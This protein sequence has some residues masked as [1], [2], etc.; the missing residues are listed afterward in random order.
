MKI[1]VIILLTFIGCQTQEIVTTTF[2][3][4]LT[5]TDI[6]SA[7]LNSYFT[8]FSGEKNIS[9]SSVCDGV[10]DCVH[11]LSDECFCFE[12]KDIH[13]MCQQ[14]VL[15]NLDNISLTNGSCTIGQ[16]KCNESDICLNP[17]QICD[18]NYDCPQNDDE[19][20]CPFDFK[21]QDSTTAVAC[22]GMATC[23]DLSDE[24]NPKCWKK[25]PYCEEATITERGLMFNGSNK[26]YH[27]S[28]LCDG[29]VDDT[30][31]KDEQFCPYSTHFYCND[32]EDKGDSK[33]RKSKRTFSHDNNT[34]FFALQ[35]KRHDSNFDCYK[36]KDECYPGVRNNMNS[37][38]KDQG[39]RVFKWLLGIVSVLGNFFVLVTTWKELM[40][41]RSLR[42]LGKQ[43]KYNRVLVLNLSISDLMMGVQLLIASIVN[44]AHYDMYCLFKFKWLTSRSCLALGILAQLSTQQSCF[45]LFIMTSYRLYG[46]LYPFQAEDSKM[47]SRVSLFI[48]ISWSVSFILAFAPQARIL[49]EYFTFKYWFPMPFW[50]SDLVEKD[51]IEKFSLYLAAFQPAN[52]SKIQNLEW[53]TMTKYI[54]ETPNIRPIHKDWKP[55][56]RKIGVYNKRSTCNMFLYPKPHEPAWHYVTIVVWLH[57][58]VVCYVIIAYVSIYCSSQRPLVRKSQRRRS[59]QWRKDNLKMQRRILFIVLTGVCCWFPICIGTILVNT[60][61]YVDA[62]YYAYTISFLLP[63][64]CALN[65]I[66]YSSL[67]QRMCRKLKTYSVPISKDDESDT[68]RS[69]HMKIRNVMETVGNSPDVNDFGENNQINGLEIPNLYKETQL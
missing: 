47:M 30:D 21:C 39:A 42:R 28:K 7:S 56:L 68:S 60:G 59:R 26:V 36:H 20:Y 18:G 15:P 58:L 51:F 16:L 48:A 46:V 10:I 57:F 9:I 52:R 35:K 31:G 45:I 66:V 67:F 2:N 17:E 8:C 11:D 64:N 40:Q 33:R 5:T 4:K 29:V 65:P 23:P 25:P 44:E 32:T 54:E 13:P 61:V 14:V 24:C 37:I 34:K 63:L 49:A 6:S 12:E 43:A 38:I 55:N 22:N 41:D 62:K 3:K 27:F 69:Q 50:K 1:I 53:Q 19:I